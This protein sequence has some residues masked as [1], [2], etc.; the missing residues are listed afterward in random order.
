[1]SHRPP[2]RLRRP[3]APAALLPTLVVLGCS[4]SATPAPPPPAPVDLEVNLR[5]AI[6]LEGE[7]PRRF[8]LQ[9]RLAHYN[10]PGVSVAVMDGGEI[11]WAQGW[12][13]A[14][15]ETGAPVTPETLF[16]AASI[17][18]PVAALAAMALVEEGAI[19][20]DGPVNRHLTS[21]R[22]PE[23]GFTGDS[24][25]TLRGILTHT[26]GLTVWGFPGYRKDRPFAEGRPMASNVEV[27]DGLGNTDP[28]RVYKV[29]GT[30][31]QYSGGGYTVMEQVVEDVTGRSFEEV[32]R[33]RV[34]EPAG[35]ARSTFAQPLPSERWPE[36]ARAHR[37]D[38]SEVAGEWHTYPE[39]AAAGLWTTPTDLLLLSR[40][41]RGVLEG[42][43]FP[44]VVSAET[45]EAMLIPHR[46]GEEGFGSHGLGFS[47]GGS[48]DDPTFGHGGSN[49]GFR[50]QWIVYRDRGQGAVVMTNGDQGGA[51]VVE[52]LRGLAELY[53]WPDFRPEVRS[54]RR[55]TADELQAYEGSYRIEEGSGP[56]ITLRVGDG[57]LLLEVAGQRNSTLHAV[58]DAAETFFDAADGQEVVFQR[59]ADGAVTGVLV[60]GRTRFVRID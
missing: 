36:A 6:E 11:A 42:G 50:A 16:Q 20:L 24:A 58:P 44:R 35:M 18:K 26:A 54:H 15:L 25:V 12:G 13:T 34:L 5:P 2:L 7:A 8:A 31:W 60:G 46:A 59:S 32:A 21:W 4:P 27:L 51:V 9:E 47:I 30:S 37:S 41:L 14:D 57:V 53:G 17:S 29:P 33:E 28:V 40:H 45:L 56:T 55:L 49:A 23:N 43:G 48:P 39:Q 19:D 52:I 38:G 10:V 3:S 1:M 22:V